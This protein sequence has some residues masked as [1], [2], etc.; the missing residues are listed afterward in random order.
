LLYFS[1]AVDHMFVMSHMT[2]SVVYS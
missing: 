2:S 1:S